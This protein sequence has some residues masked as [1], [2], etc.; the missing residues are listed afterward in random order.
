M[1][2]L[3][4]P[5]AIEYLEV[6]RCWFYRRI[7]PTYNLKQV[8]KNGNNMLYSKEDLDRIKKCKV[9]EA[10]MIL[11]EFYKEQEHKS[12]GLDYEE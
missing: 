10:A 3:T 4:G 6:S 7:K 12:G 11:R 1:E 2:L 9:N 8:S 5:E